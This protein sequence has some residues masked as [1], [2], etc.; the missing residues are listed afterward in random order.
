MK[1]PFSFA[2]TALSSFQNFREIA[3]LTPTAP[4]AARRIAG[5]IREEVGT[6]I[7]LGPGSGAVTRELVKKLGTNS[8]LIVVE[9]Q[10]KFADQLEEEFEDDPRVRVY[11][12]S[13]ESIEEIMEKEDETEATHVF[14]SIPMSIIPR[15]IVD[16]ILES[17]SRVMAPNGK[18]VVF[19]CR[20]KIGGILRDHFPNARLESIEILNL[21]PLLVYE[22]TAENVESGIIE[23]RM[24]V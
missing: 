6:A 19:Q 16:N 2:K 8:K 20:F 5:R 12:G 10:S 4:W 15:P 7:E 13:A 21:P 23:A 18:L 17:T 24:S 9:M 14:S 22:A 3:S 1:N 11:R